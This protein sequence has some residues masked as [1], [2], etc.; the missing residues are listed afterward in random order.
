M[1]V[2]PSHASLTRQGNHH[3]NVFFTFQGPSFYVKCVQGAIS[4]IPRGLTNRIVGEG[5]MTPFC[6]ITFFRTAD[7]EETNQ[8]IQALKIRWKHKIKIYGIP[9]KPTLTLQEIKFLNLI[10][11]NANNPQ[12]HKIMIYILLFS[13]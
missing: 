6:S 2:I 7:S 9:N 12:K 13:P 1:T 3:R 4:K 11:Q 5:V 10:H 8:F